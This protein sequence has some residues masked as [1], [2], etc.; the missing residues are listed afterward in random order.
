MLRTQV[1]ELN[2]TSVRSVALA[3]RPDSIMVPCCAHTNKPKKGLQGG[4]CTCLR[5]TRRRAVRLTNCLIRRTTV[6]RASMADSGSADEAASMYF[7]GYMSGTCK[8]PCASTSYAHAVQG[9]ASAKVASMPSPGLCTRC[10]PASAN[11][12]PLPWALKTSD[13]LL[14]PH[15]SFERLPTFCAESFS[16]PS[17]ARGNRFPVGPL[18]VAVRTA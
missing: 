1:E 5:C 11:T 12:L 6:Q 15:E 8:Y 4:A 16:L 13:K 3:N 17:I 2:L 9:A 10:M 18:R 7:H 14:F